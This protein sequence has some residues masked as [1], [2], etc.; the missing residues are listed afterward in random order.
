[1]CNLVSVP[2]WWYVLC[3][4]IVIVEKQQCKV[5]ALSSCASNRVAGSNFG[6]VVGMLRGVLQ[7]CLL[8]MLRCR[9]RSSSFLQPLS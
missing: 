4:F 5:Q 8:V 3:S 1:M 9:L 7:N 6:F 2:S